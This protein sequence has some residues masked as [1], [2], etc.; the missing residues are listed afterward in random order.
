MSAKNHA[1]V[2]LH[3]MLSPDLKQVYDI[4]LA[5]IGQEIP[6]LNTIARHLINA[7]GKRLR[8]I[9]TLASCHAVGKITDAAL[10]LSAAVELIHTATLLHDDVI[11]VS[12]TRRHKKTANSLWSNQA[13][14]LV[15][16][17]LFARSFNLM[18]K[19]N[20]IKILDI[21]ANVSSQI[22]EGE[23]LQLTY[24]HK[25]TQTIE[26][27]LSV[28]KAKTA[29]LFAAACQVGALVGGVDLK[30]SMY[31]YQF[32]LNFG[33]AYQIVDDVLDYSVEH[34]KT[35]GKNT[36]QD[37]KEGKVTLPIILAFQKY[38]DKALWKRC[39]QSIQSHE[40][41]LAKI[42]NL[43]QESDIFQQCIGMAKSFTDQA[44]EKLQLANLDNQTIDLLKNLAI[45]CLQRNH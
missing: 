7:G 20:N 17:F 9:L 38:P 42:T 32:G 10:S 2:Q 15:G 40:D 18:V 43:M 30:T 12:S 25:L 44:I 11:D 13:C 33:I 8:P 1:L 6:L 4:I 37:F 41:D 31:F 21:L 14:I 45:E 27:Y 19:S 3:D 28:I 23:I 5:E 29:V 39:F 24:K 34:Q 35:I 22:A 16:D 36:G 26:D